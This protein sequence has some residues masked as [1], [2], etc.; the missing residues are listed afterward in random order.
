MYS[1]NHP[2][3]MQHIHTDCF[4]L[5]H[6]HTDTRV[7]NWNCCSPARCH[8]P[9]PAGSVALHWEQM[10]R[11]QTCMCVCLCVE[12]LEQT[13]ERCAVMFFLYFC[14]I[15]T[16]HMWRVWKFKHFCVYLCMC[17]HESSYM[18]VCVGVCLQAY[19]VGG[20]RK[21]QELPAIE[22]RDK[23]YVCDSERWFFFIQFSLIT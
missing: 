2:T 1:E 19:G 21:R 9:P 16:S 4:T 10:I 13:H 15:H 23:P 14:F 5:T 11:I 12:A 6:T 8:Q 17:L 20:M 18:C 7:A 3:H 22:D